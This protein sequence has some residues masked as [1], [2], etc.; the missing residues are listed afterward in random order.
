MAFEQDSSITF[1]VGSEEEVERDLRKDRA[2]RFVRAIL[3]GLVAGAGLAAGQEALRR[4]GFDG[5]RRD[6]TAMP[7]V[8]RSVWAGTRARSGRYAAALAGDVAAGTLFY[9]ALMG[10]TPMRPI[11]RGLT[12]GLLAGAAAVLLPPLL[13]G[14]LRAPHLAEVANL[15]LHVV[16]GLVAAGLYSA[17]GRRPIGH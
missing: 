8:A 7:G 6:R 12:G 14:R 3:S 5:V 16:A 15:G 10:G 2:R 1:G 13:R 4:A 11:A 9:S 17:L